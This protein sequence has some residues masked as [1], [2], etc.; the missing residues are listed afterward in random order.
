[1]TSG[2]GT[3]SGTRIG[4]GSGT[5]TGTGT[6]TGTATGRRTTVA[7][8]ALLCA[9]ALP[10]PSTALAHDCRAA[11]ALAHHH[12]AAP[13]LA[14]HHRAAP[15]LTHDLQAAPALAH[16][17]RV[18]PAPALVRVRPVPPAAPRDR[19]A[20]PAVA[21]SVDVTD[22]VDHADAGQRLDY[23]VTVHNLGATGLPGTRIEQQMPATTAA[24]TA[25][26][27]TV[28]DDG[29]GARKAV[30][31]TDLGAYDEQVFTASATL[32]ERPTPAGTTAPG[33][34][35][36]AVTVCVYVYGR[37][38]PAACSGDLDDLPETHPEGP[39]TGLVWWALALG[40]CAVLAPG[41][42]RAV[43]RR[44]GGDGRGDSDGSGGGSA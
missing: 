42:H 22:G 36:A 25:D 39:G 37:A 8:C 30:W 18:A 2:I 33:T 44:R 34:L 43:R 41:V 29:T 7:V 31:R 1:M 16:D 35:R 12:R 11:P 5:G 10:A 27:G 4:T 13:A 24:A 17:R 3:G 9:A 21:V 6:T 26:G 20:P 14:H 32:G 40:V 38:A 15:A 23:R 19:E 28:V